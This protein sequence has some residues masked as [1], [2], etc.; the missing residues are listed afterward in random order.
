MN[1]DL[2]TFVLGII[3]NLEMILNA[4]ENVLHYMQVVCILCKTLEHPWILVS[5]ED[6]K[7]NSL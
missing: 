4:Q 2:Y 3:S 1:N 5:F 6:P 7:K